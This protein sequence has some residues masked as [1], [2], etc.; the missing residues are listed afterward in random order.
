VKKKILGIT[1]KQK[2]VVALERIGEA[3]RDKASLF[4]ARRFLSLC[5]A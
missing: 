4:V 2:L 1:I 3:V 5:K